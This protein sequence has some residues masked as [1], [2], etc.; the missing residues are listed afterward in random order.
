MWSR[1][2]RKIGLVQPSFNKFVCCSYHYFSQ[3]FIVLFKILGVERQAY[4]CVWWAFECSFCASGMNTKSSNFLILIFVPFT[5]TRDWI[6]QCLD[7]LGAVCVWFIWWLPWFVS[8]NDTF[9]NLINFSLFQPNQRNTLSWMPFWR[10]SSADW[11]FWVLQQLHRY[12]SL[13]S[14]H[15]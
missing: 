12:E 4:L 10:K 1:D 3:S 11:L 9:T 8:S 5:A 6:Q 15:H 7:N 2:L 14:S 13:V